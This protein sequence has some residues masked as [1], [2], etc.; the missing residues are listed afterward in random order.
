MRM[1]TQTTISTHGSQRQADS[2]YVTHRFSNYETVLCYLRTLKVKA[3]VYLRQWADVKH[4]KYMNVVS[5]PCV[6]G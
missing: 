6:S 1:C 3:A 5:M 2:R 4:H